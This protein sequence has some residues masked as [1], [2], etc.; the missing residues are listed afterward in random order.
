MEAMGKTIRALR[1]EQGLSQAQLAFE[2][3]ITRN[4]IVSIES[5]KANFTMKTLLLICSVLNVRPPDIWPQD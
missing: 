1:K 5:G 3:G 2:A 4:Q